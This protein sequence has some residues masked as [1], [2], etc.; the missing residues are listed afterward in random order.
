[1]Y[2][3]TVFAS[4]KDITDEISE[5]TE[6]TA[7]VLR[8]HYCIWSKEVM[9]GY[10]KAYIKSYAIAVICGNLVNGAE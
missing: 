10:T 5:I 7:I 2:A 6:N 8:N 3:G 9:A 1:M 4:E